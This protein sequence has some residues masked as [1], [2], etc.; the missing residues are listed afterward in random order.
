MGKPRLRRVLQAHEAL[1]R[2]HRVVGTV[3]GL[4]LGLGIRRRGRVAD[5]EDL[6]AVDVV[7]G[8]GTIAGGD[9]ERVLDDGT[10]LLSEEVTEQKTDGTVVKTFRQFR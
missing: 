2:A 6:V 3:G 1:D 9:E 4:E 5:L 10:T 8:E 7:L